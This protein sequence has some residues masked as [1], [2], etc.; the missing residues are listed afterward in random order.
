MLYFAYGSNM[1]WEQMRMRCPSSSFVTTATLPGHRLAFTRR[2][3]IRKCG[4][5]DVVPAPFGE[6]WGVVYRIVRRADIERLDRREGF[7]ARG[8]MNA[9]Q[10][11]T[12]HV[13]ANGNPMRRMSVDVYQ[14]RR[15]VLAPPPSE[16]Y[17]GHLLRG[18]HHW[19]LPATYIAA[20]ER[21]PTA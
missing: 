10:R 9:Y 11:R 7:R 12:V 15:H 6:V 8:R 18:A 3:K 17:M 4:V 20:L 21:V 2:S 1:D 5:A 13:H 19:A 14:A 16:D